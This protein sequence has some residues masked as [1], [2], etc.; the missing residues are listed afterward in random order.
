MKTQKRGK[1][2]VNQHFLIH[3]GAEMKILCKEV[4][5]A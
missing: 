2:G 5:Q 3:S 4:S 1:L